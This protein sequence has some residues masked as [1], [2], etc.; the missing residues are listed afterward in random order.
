MKSIEARIEFLKEC[1]DKYE[2]NGTSP[3]SDKEYDDE[4]DA[5]YKIAPDNP[6]FSEVGGLDE[7]HIYGTPFTHVTMMGSLS[8]SKDIEDFEKW[9]I[10]NYKDSEII[11]LAE[12]KVDGLSLSCHYEN[13]KLTR[14]VT[15]GDGEIGVD[16]TANAVHVNGILTKIECKDKFEVRGECYKNRKEFDADW[17]DQYANSR[18][19]TAGSINQKDALETKKRGLSF[20]AY[21][22]V[23]KEF[24]TEEQKMDF[25]KK[26]GFAQLNLEDHSAVIIR[27]SLKDIIK[28]VKAYMD[29]IDRNTLN[30][31]IDGIVFKLNDIRM[32]Q[33]MGTTD[34]GRKPKANRAIK[35]PCDQK[36]T[37][38]IGVEWSCGRIGTVTPVGILSPIQLDG[39]TVERVTLHNAKL[40][41]EMGLQIG[42]HVR[43]QK[44]GQIIPYIVR[45]TKDGDKAIEIPTKCPTC[46][47]DL[48]WN[49]TE[50]HKVCTN[51]VCEA[52]ISNTIEHWFKTI[53][54]KGLGSGIIEKLVNGSDG[55]PSIKS[56]SA[57]YSLDQYP[58][59][60]LF[61]KKA[62]SNILESV[63]SVKEMDLAKFIEALGIGKIGSM[64]SELTAIAPTIA[65]IDKLTVSDITK[66]HGFADKKASGFVNG[67]KAMRK[68]IDNIL[69]FVT[70][71][72]KV[73]ASNSLEGKSFCVTGVLS[74]PR[75][76]FESLITDNGGKISSVSK[77]LSYLIVG[78]DAGSK[79]EKGQKLGIKIID[80]KQFMAML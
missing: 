80:E 38:L 34:G 61:G 71:K 77:N 35:F 39:T 63:S 68:E 43:I 8:K 5:C 14:V 10:N 44:S 58:L 28:S 6:F 30:Y 2:T 17:A 36:D 18:N 37:E 59:G 51:P 7:E 13:G 62:F 22:V 74:K 15:R 53:G 45:K 19:F 32:A 73:M 49:D 12:H 48:I 33:E 24:K 50:I 26:M 3:L 56:I 31:D 66:I 76:Y 55:C 47:S 11:A 57:M 1:A 20:I 69:K 52:V 65:D 72:E 46:K 75:S 41:Q 40:I 54:S 70:I 29:S 23:G 16:V 64:A 67:W 60:D 4:F 9:L 25:I 78:E 27:G 42:C 79:L 21:E